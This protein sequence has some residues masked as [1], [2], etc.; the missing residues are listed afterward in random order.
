MRIRCPLSLSLILCLLLGCAP[1]PLPDSDTALASLVEAERAFART[2]VEEGTRHAFLEFLADDAIV[3]R[4]TPTN[5]K[6]WFAPR[7][8]SSRTLAWQPV[9]ADVA[10]TGDLGYTTGPYSVSDS[11]GA[12]LAHGHYVTVWRLQADSTWRV[13]IDAGSSHPQ[14]ETPAP[15]RIASPDDTTTSEALNKLYRESARV[16]LLKTDRDMA[17]ASAAQGSVAAFSA[18]LADSVRFYRSGAFP[19]IGKAAMEAMLARG[20]GVLSWVPVNAEVS[21]AGDLGYTYGLATFR[22]STDDS[23]AASSTYLRIWKRPPDG[24]WTL[25]LD[26][27]APL[28]EE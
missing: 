5:G 9:F 28:P 4:P 10:D 27:A 26:L 25:V 15:D 17:E 23:T 21:Q 8:E 22:A 24:S 12:L 3:F 14:P 18:V 13:E 19:Q 11:T 2:S 16:N 6:E 1:E 20:A 7:P